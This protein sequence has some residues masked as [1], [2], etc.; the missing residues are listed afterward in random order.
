MVNLEEE[1]KARG[2]KPSFG[3][4][5]ESRDKKL[6]LKAVTDEDKAGEEAFQV[7]TTS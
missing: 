3:P 1:I 4:M 5:S 7:S 6:L 2:L